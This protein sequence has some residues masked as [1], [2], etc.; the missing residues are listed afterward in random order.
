[1]YKILHKMGKNDYLVELYLHIWNIL[2]IKWYNN[3]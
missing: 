1:M 2:K 3:I